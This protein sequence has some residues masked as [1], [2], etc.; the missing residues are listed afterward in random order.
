MY[1]NLFERLLKILNPYRSIRISV[2]FDDEAQFERFKKDYNPKIKIV[3]DWPESDHIFEAIETKVNGV[4]IEAYGPAKPNPSYDSK[5]RSEKNEEARKK[6]EIDDRFRREVERQGNPDPPLYEGLKED[7]D[8]TYLLNTMPESTNLIEFLN[9]FIS[10]IK[11]AG[12]E[13]SVESTPE[14]VAKNG[15]IVVKAPKSKS[16][17]L[18]HISRRRLN[19]Q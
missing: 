15:L 12:W 13:V 16:W 1:L 4:K 8:F 18:R 19:D 3:G 9:S 5:L 10:R 7:V 6:R 11:E 2:H 17:S 14:D